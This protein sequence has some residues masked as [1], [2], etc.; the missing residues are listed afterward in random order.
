MAIEFEDLSDDEFTSF[1]NSLSDKDKAKYNS[2]TPEQQR[3]VRQGHKQNLKY[4]GLESSKHTPAA[5]AN[6]DIV[7]DTLRGGTEQ[8]K[9]GEEVST[10]LGSIEGG[11][12][13]LNERQQELADPTPTG[14]KA[15]EETNTEGSVYTTKNL[16]EQA[17][18]DPT[19]RWKMKSI[20]EAYYD[21]SIDRSTRNYMLADSLSTFARNTGKDLANVAAAYTGG[22]VDNERDTSLWEA[23]NAELAKSAI[24]SEKAGV[25]GSR[26]QREYDTWASN[27]LMRYFNNLSAQERFNMASQLD[28]YINNAPND[29][30][31]LKYMDIK[32]KMLQ[33][34]RVDETDLAFSGVG[35]L[36]NKISSGLHL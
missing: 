26:E 32:N 4:N 35:E 8:N 28:Q 22:T 31:K 5:L 21:G 23:R 27:Q 15:S 10:G 2:M 7:Q 17:K 24:E 1:M 25:S 19:Q 34:G 16:M 6:N 9:A 29:T 12:K 20:M 36:W 33:G 14:G 13:S 30:I 3:T 18:I 11:D